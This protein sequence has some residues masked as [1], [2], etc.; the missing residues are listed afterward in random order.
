MYSIR[1][2]VP[3]P[4]ARPEGCPF[5]PRCDRFMAGTCDRRAPPVVEVAPDHLVRCWLYQE[6]V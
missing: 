2:M 6:I 3:H 5:H 4:F 1:G